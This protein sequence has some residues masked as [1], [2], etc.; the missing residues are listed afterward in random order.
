MIELLLYPPTLVSLV[1]ALVAAVPIAARWLRVA[2]REHYVPG[3]VSRMAWLWVMREPFTAVILVL[4]I[5]ATYAAVLS[6]VPPL[7]PYWSLVSLLL[8]ALVP[9]GLPVRGR[10][11][12]FAITARVKRLMVCWISLHV[13]VTVV[14]VWVL[15]YGAAAAPA[16]V[17]LLSAPLTDLALAIMAPI[18]KAA[19][20]RFVTQA[21]KRLQQTGA[22]VVAITGSY[23]KTSTKN[24]V[25]HLL[26]ASF[27]TV[28]S[29]ASFN[30]RL[31]LARAVNDK[32]VPGTEMFVA[33]MGMAAPGQIAQLCRQFPPSI[34]AITVIGEGHLQRMRTTEAILR[35]KS[36]ITEHAP[37]V[38]LP[39]D[40]PRLAE[41]ADRCRAA[42]KTVVTTTCQAGVD[43]DV[44][45]TPPADGAPDAEPWLI[46]LG[47]GAEPVPVSIGST[48]HAV[49]VAVAAGIAVAAGVPAAAIA[50]R[51]GD[52]PGSQHRAEVQQAPT[53]AL[54]I[55]DTYN[56]NPVGSLR[57]L[58][59]AASLAAERGGTLVVVTPGMVELGPVQAERNR[60]FGAAIGAA[61]GLLF[62]VARTNRAALLAGYASTATSEAPGAMAVTTREQAVRRAVEAAGDRGVILY[63]ND[64]PDHYP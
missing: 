39:I 40:D 11:A 12:K 20:Q 51:L 25:A 16:L 42:G 24:Y 9:L 36:S 57:A 56:A 1:V 2:Q 13:G 60:A 26:S 47:T 52:L 59:G 64:L 54:V 3:S 23:G 8:L 44:A 19:S 41:L 53:G 46:R 7:G 31:G 62:A 33:E 38:V 61:D 17:L 14:L 15:G 4:V 32:L 29:P 35:E 22:R 55:D 63:E 45:L 28:A 58:E 6:G 49:N 50:A 34:A 27:T 37:I 10:S 18:E 5:G 21:Q 43:A 48:G 30:N